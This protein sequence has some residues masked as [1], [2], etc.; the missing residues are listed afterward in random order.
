MLFPLFSVNRQFVFGNFQLLPSA[1]D[2]SSNLI[3][4]MNGR[5]RLMF[6][7][8]HQALMLADDTGQFTRHA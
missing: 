3:F 8:G 4:I 2:L 7:I 1:F 5:F 6:G